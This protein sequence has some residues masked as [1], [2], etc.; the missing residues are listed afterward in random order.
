MCF[1]VSFRFQVISP[2][3]L[4]PILE[5]SQ[6][7]VGN[8]PIRLE[9]RLSVNNKSKQRRKNNVIKEAKNLLQKISTLAR[10]GPFCHHF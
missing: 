5:E 4:S 7:I 2:S 9:G 1:Q 8:L 10:F 6:V 3:H